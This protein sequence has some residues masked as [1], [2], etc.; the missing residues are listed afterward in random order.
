MCGDQKAMI[1]Q[2]GDT[3]GFGIGACRRITARLILEP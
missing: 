1:C 3:D 2:R